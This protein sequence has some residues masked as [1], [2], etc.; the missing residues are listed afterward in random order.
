[1]NLETVRVSALPSDA[2]DWVV[3][4]LTRNMQKMYEESEWGWN[5]KNK[6]AEMLE[7]AAWYLVATEKESGDRMGFCHFRFDMDCDDEVL[8]VYEVQVR[9][10]CSCSIAYPS[11]IQYIAPIAPYSFQ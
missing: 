1:M 11:Y 8:Y 4:L 9:I 5:A 7:E 3:D 6:R 2:Q 10:G